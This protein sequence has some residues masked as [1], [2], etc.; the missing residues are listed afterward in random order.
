MSLDMP[1]YSG[2]YDPRYAGT[3]S[4]QHPYPNPNTGSIHTGSIPVGWRAFTSRIPSAWVGMSAYLVAGVLL[5]VVL[6]VALS[7]AG[8]DPP[9]RAANA[10][11]G[12]V[13]DNI[14]RL[15]GKDVNAACWRGIAE[16]GPLR[17]TVSLEVGLDGKV[18]SAAANGA[19]PTMRSC[20][21]SHVRGWE[22][23]PQSAPSTMVLPFEI[24]N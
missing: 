23:L 12:Q 8:N 6:L 1:V 18:R 15:K 17:V 13:S 11:A 19:S 3:G 20:V 7:L 22:F 16:K 21:E 14:V 24:S 10:T 4:F 5:G 9:A 2:G